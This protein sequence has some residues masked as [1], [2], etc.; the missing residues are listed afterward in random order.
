MPSMIMAKLRIY[1]PIGEGCC[2][3]DEE[4]TTFMSVAEFIDSI[5]AD[6]NTIELLINSPGGSVAE[7]WAIVDKLR[8]TGKRITATIEGTCAS[9]ASVVLLAASERRAYPHATLLIHNPFFPE[10]SLADAYDAEALRR[11]ADSLDEDTRKILDFYVERT[12]ASREELAA[13]MAEDKSVDMTRAKE[14]GFIQEIIPPASAFHQTKNIMSKDTKQGIFERITAAI[15]VALGV[16]DP[17]P[18][19]Y[20]LT[21]EDGTIIT[22]EKP[23][24]EE[25]AVGD[26]ARPDGRHRL[27]SGITLVIEAGEIVEIVEEEIKREPGEEAEID[28]LKKENE[29]LRAEL[30]SLKSA[31]KSDEEVEILAL[32]KRV[33]GIA[34]LKEFSSNYQ[35]SKRDNMAD[36]TVAPTVADQIRAIRE[37]R[38]A[39]FKNQKQIAHGKN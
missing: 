13:L 3:F 29:E 19:A 28:A 25:P 24:G 1:T 23:E 12:G 37:K 8:A 14:L 10:F 5:P 38:T 11:L 33:G 26:V 22:I 21:A 16:E 32:V 4:G 36:K 6:D 34:K 39:E 30:E 31:A 20:E 9:M 15:A 7:G 2:F 35:P 17:T 18:V 27:P